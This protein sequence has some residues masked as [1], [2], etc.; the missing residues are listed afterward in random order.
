MF[1]SS[2]FPKAKKYWFQGKIH[3]ISKA[4]IHPFTHTLH[5][6]TSVFEGIRAYD[7]EQGPAI[8]RLPEHMDRFFHSASVLK[9]KV[10]HSKEDIVSIIKTVMKE[11]QLKSAYIRPLLF[12]SFGN[13][14]LTPKFC[15]VELLVAAWE[16]G[17]YLG[18]KA[19]TGV[20]VYILPQ[21]RIHH[22]QFDMGAKLG[23]AYVQSTICGMTAREKGFDEALFLN[24]EGH[25]AEG[26][27]E[28]IFI[29]HKGILKTNDKTAS[30]LEGITRTSI[31][32]IAEEMGIK[33]SVAPITKNELFEADE[34]FFCGTAAEVTPI[35]RITDGSEKAENPSEIKIGTGKSG[36][37]TQKI[38]ETYLK[39]VQ[40][41]IPK[42]HKWLT[43]IND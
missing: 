10:Q 38:R 36:E 42:Y 14:G 2:H 40:G 22:S 32:E 28:N 18:D 5:Y 43:L 41:K 21:K 6:G 34:A 3:E 1:N 29:Y 12:Y 24:L 30:I 27:G 33:T 39:V 7:S 35:I 16:W 8:F 15:P 25:I 17:A 23:G 20:N 11:N 26:P 37:F 4:S 31:L 13:L 19:V 9:M